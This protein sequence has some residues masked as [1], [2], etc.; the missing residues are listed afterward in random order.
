MISWT[1]TQTQRL[2]ELNAE[3]SAL[4]KIFADKPTREAAHQALEK[5]LVTTQRSQLAE[6]QATHRRP[7]LCRLD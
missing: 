4:K 1:Q 3:D 2:K 6:F 5:T 7:E